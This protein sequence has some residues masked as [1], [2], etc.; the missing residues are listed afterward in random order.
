MLWF[1]LCL[2]LLLELGQDLDATW[3]VLPRLVQDVVFVSRS[4][5]LLSVVDDIGGHSDNEHPSQFSCHIRSYHLSFNK[6]LCLTGR[7]IM[8]TDLIAD[9]NPHRYTSLPA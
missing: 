5:G 9:S 6:A 4:E 7:M 8:D 2:R 3:K 1:W